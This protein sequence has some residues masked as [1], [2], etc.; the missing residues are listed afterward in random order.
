MAASDVSEGPVLSVINKRLRALRK[1]Y[2]RIVQ[3]EESVSK[4]KTLNKEQEETLRSKPAVIAG[5]DEL[6]KLREPLASAVA[7]EI[8][9]ATSV[10]ATPDNN[11][12]NE[13]EG[14]GIMCVE[15][16]L[17][18]LYF[19]C[20]FD[21]KSLQSDFSTATMLTRTHER[22]CCLNYDCMPEDESS[23]V[24]NL[25][26]EKDLDLISMLSGLLISRPVN[27]PLSHKRALQQCIEHAK[28]WLTK[29]DQPIVPDSDATYAGLK[30]KLNRIMSSLY[31]TTDPVKVEA[32]AAN[33][34]PYSVPVEESVPVNEPVQLHTIA[35]QSQQ[36][37][38]ECL[39]SQGNHTNEMHATTVE[40]IQQ[41]VQ[42]ENLSELPAEAE[43]VTPEAEGDNNLKDMNFKEQQSVPRRSYENQNYRGHRNGDGGG[44]RGYSNGRGGRGRGGSYQNGRNQYYDQSGNY[45][46]KSQNNSYRG[47]G[48]RGTV[49]GNY[50]PHASGGQA[51]N[52]S[53]DA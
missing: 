16:L 36:K 40:E 45:Y 33:Y 39:S 34:G 42:G 2:N 8:N 48:G 1:K 50:N 52:F 17:Y 15:D 29:S 27:S 23:D 13:G 19:G 7:E 32:A 41:G 47:R 30:S 51:A 28:L 11:S 22:A 10:S 21:V 37:E 5:I 46:Q 25:L 43:E 3:M 14:E 31:F 6:E 12:K 44:R 26:G 38:E 49:G 24:V 35:M 4:G 20:M 53:V 9:L 18:L